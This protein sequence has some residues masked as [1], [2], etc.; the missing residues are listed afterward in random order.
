MTER[1]AVF[2]VFVTFLRLERPNSAAIV[3]TSTSLDD[4]RALSRGINLK[5]AVLWRGSG[6]IQA[7]RQLSSS[8][9]LH[10]ASSVTYRYL[11][12]SSHPLIKPSPLLVEAANQ[13]EVDPRDPL[14]MALL[15]SGAR[16]KPFLI[17]L[18]KQNVNVN[19]SAP[20][21]APRMME[22]VISGASGVLSAA[23]FA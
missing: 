14:L 22:K 8:G 17:Q 1:K 16:K 21:S 23:W 9:L 10:G 6:R 15:A 7:L 11:G 3:T 18:K 2:T 20:A 4:E 12:L 13:P 19:A 5:I